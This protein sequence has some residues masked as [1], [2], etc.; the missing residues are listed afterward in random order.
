MDVVGSD[1]EKLGSVDRME[2]DY[3]V[4]SKGF[5]FPTDYYIP[6]DAIANVDEDRVYLN[7]TKDVALDQGWDMAPTETSTS[8]MYADDTSMADPVSTP[9][10]GSVGRAGV[11]GTAGTT[12][13]EV[14][15]QPFE[16]QAHH[17]HSHAD[18]SDTIRVPLSEEEVT[19]TKRTVD[20]GAV[21]IE[22]DVIEEEQTLDVPV[23]EERVNVTR[24]TVDRDV[25]AGET[26]FEGGTIEVPVRGEE[27]DVEKR[28]RVTE[29]LEISKEA[30]QDTQR[31]TDTVRREEG[32]VTDDSGTVTGDSGSVNRDKPSL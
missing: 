11:T 30:V 2:G 19:A 23:P 31:V 25:A 28:S 4:A 14:A 29:E 18:D 20:R 3:V 5:F 8:T 6:V 13:D 10:G 16:H 22:K 17:E 26:T 21:Q 12:A 7:V 9:M 27:V 24:R 32:R 15:D 1:G